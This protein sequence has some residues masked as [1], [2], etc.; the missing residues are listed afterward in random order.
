MGNSSNNSHFAI[1]HTDP[2]NNLTYLVDPAS[3]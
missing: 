1:H 3:N 2:D